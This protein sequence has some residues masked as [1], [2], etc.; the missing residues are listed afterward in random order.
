M[1]QAVEELLADLDLEKKSVVVGAS[2]VR[3]RLPEEVNPA[4]GVHRCASVSGVH[5][6]RSAALPG[7][8]EG[9]AGRPLARP[10]AGGLHGTPG[11]PEIPT[12]Q[13]QQM[14]PHAN[15][16]GHQG[17]TRGTLSVVRC[18][19]RGGASRLFIKTIELVK[20]N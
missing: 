3:T 17:V 4:A 2:R 14:N 7:A 8:A 18:S 9:P 5:E 13:G 6:A 1:P 11:P 10:P 15:V 16:G 12:T 20:V 19:K